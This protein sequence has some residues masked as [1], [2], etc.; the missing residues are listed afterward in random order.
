MRDP[1]PKGYSISQNRIGDTKNL[2]YGVNYE[3]GY[4]YLIGLKEDAEFVDEIVVADYYYDPDTDEYYPVKRILPRAFMGNNDIT[5]LTVLSNMEVIGAG[6]FKNCKNL[7]DIYLYGN[8][9]LSTI[10]QE[11]FYS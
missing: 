6:A 8:G 5:R 10:E 11:V 4:A 9:K 3:E 1:S 2:E 7:N